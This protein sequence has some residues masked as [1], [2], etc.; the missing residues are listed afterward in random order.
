MDTHQATALFMVVHSMVRVLLKPPQP[1]QGW[2]EC[3]E[4]CT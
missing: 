1:T 3:T 2:Q 4:R